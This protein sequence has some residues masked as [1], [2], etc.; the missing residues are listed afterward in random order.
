MI[1]LRGELW[2]SILGVHIPLPKICWDRRVQRREH[3][4]FAPY[5]YTSCAHPLL[6]IVRC[7][8]SWSHECTSRRFVGKGGTNS[9]LKFMFWT[10]LTD[11]YFRVAALAFLNQVD[12]IEVGGVQQFESWV[13]LTCCWN[14]RGNSMSQTHPFPGSN[15]PFSCA[16]DITPLAL[17]ILY[18]I[19]I[20]QNLGHVNLCQV[21]LHVCAATYVHTSKPTWFLAYILAQQYLPVTTSGPSTVNSNPP[22]SHMDWWFSPRA[23]AGSW[24]DHFFASSLSNRPVLLNGEPWSIEI[25]LMQLLPA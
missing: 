13:V 25:A 2:A 23:A 6:E 21:C 16:M 8:L 12:W 18:T 20:Q 14:M 1:C 11:A 24:P 7:E 9:C 17:Q 3:I 10:R 5:I 4:K 22:Q 15:K 19:Q